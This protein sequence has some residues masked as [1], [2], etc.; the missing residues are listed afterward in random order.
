MYPHL[1]KSILINYK[2][3]ITNWLFLYDEVRLFHTQFNRRMASS[4]DKRII[5]YVKVAWSLPYKSLTKIR[6]VN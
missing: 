5:Y 4:C 1:T 2:R 3:N 6:C